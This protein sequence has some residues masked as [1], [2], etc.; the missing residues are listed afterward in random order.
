[1]IRSFPVRGVMLLAG[2]MPLLGSCTYMQ[3]FRP[4]AWMAVDGPNATLNG[5]PVQGDSIAIRNNDHVVTGTDT[6][7]RIQFVSPRGT[8]VQL[9]QNTDPDVFAETDCLW[10]RMLRGKLFS[11]GT[12]LC[13][14]SPDLAAALNSEVS[15]SALPTK[16]LRGATRPGCPGGRRGTRRSH[17]P[18]AH[19]CGC[20]PAGDCRRWQ[21]S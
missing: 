8:F 4:L 10:V 21:D 9:D 17:A 14:D 12:G 19:Q 18:D 3:Q 13:V 6:S 15:L 20:T 11:Q 5:Q 2:L 1:M 7:V 16:K